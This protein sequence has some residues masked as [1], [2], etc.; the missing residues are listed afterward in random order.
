MKFGTLASL[1]IFTAIDNAIGIALAGSEPQKPQFFVGDANHL[2][3]L[4]MEA[5]I[6]AEAAVHEGQSLPRKGQVEVLC[7]GPPCQGFTGLNR[8]WDQDVYHLKN[9]LVATYLSVRYYFDF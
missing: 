1:R 8:H 7:G 6:N 4:A 3:K 2:L 9:S 5:E